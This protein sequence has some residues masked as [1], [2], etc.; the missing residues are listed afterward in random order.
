MLQN[1]QARYRYAYVRDTA[2]GY[3]ILDT[4]TDTDTDTVGYSCGSWQLELDTGYS[5][6]WICCKMAR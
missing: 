4:Y 5:G 6:Q 1:N 2:A 3:W